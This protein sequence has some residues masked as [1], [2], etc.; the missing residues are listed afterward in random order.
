MVKSYIPQEDRDYRIYE[1]DGL[2]HWEST[3]AI[4]GSDY[5]N[6]EAFALPGDAEE[7]A[8]EFLLEQLVLTAPE[9]QQL[10]EHLVQLPASMVNAL[11]SGVMVL[12]E[13][14]RN[15]AFYRWA[16]DTP[17]PAWCRPDYRFTNVPC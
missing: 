4:F 14:G 13:A 11:R 8:R 15:R 1:L 9:Q 5:C 3:G 6:D 10:A 2:F 12:P 17:I 7:E 16:M